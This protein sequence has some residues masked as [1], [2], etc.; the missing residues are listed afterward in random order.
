MELSPRCYH[1]KL[2]G[3]VAAG[4]DASAVALTAVDVQALGAFDRVKVT[5]ELGTVVDLA[6]LEFGVQECDTADGTYKVIADLGEDPLLITGKSEGSVIF[7][8]PVTKKYVQVIYKR[9]TKNTEFDGIF[10]DLY[11]GMKIPVVQNTAVFKEIV[12]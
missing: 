3:N 1:K 2:A 8:V 7:D 5:L 6:T 4:V 9:T 11:D 10:I 12:K